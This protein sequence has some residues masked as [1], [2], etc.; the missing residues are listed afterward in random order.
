[1]KFL[2][3]AI[4]PAVLVTLTMMLTG[5]FFHPERIPEPYV[6]LF[7]GLWFLTWAVIAL[8]WATRIVRY[9]FRQ[10]KLSSHVGD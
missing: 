4:S 8:Y 9:V 5:V 10:G 1:M 6:L 3:I 2:A 7:D